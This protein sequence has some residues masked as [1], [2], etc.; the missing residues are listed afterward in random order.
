MK[1]PTTFSFFRRPLALLLALTLGGVIWE[2]RV[3]FLWRDE[4]GNL[5]KSATDLTARIGRQRD[6]IGRLRAQIQVWQAGTGSSAKAS[7]PGSPEAQVSQWASQLGKFRKYFA[8]HPDQA[9]P[10]MSLLTQLDWLR[11][12]R[13]AQLDDASESRKAYAKVRNE[14]RGK[15]NA[16][17]SPVLRKYLAEHDGILPP[18][19][20]E[21]APYLDPSIDPAIIGH[22]RMIFS[23]KSDAT[24]G[25]YYT[26]ENGPPADENYDTRYYMGRSNGAI[27]GWLDGDLLESKQA[28]RI[29]YNQS[30]EDTKY[31]T[32]PNEN[33]SEL[34]PYITSPVHRAYLAA[35]IAYASANGGKRPQQAGDL[36]PYVS[37][38]ET[39]GFA[40]KIL[41]PR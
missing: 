24:D 19:T 14:A 20:A 10:E 3:L 5:Q 8:D 12:V 29:A 23:G 38:S 28:A 32:G 9:I 27:T 33:L 7:E 30:H 13:T 39:R 35:T 17:L 6:E 16:L 40:E 22:Y 15:F 36:S 1:A 41:A 4:G 21:L 25:Y 11:L 26:A 34:L 18:S 37:D 31:V 2:T